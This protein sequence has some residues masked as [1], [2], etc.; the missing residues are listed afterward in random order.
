MKV[1]STI[2][3]IFFSFICLWT[4]TVANG[5]ANTSFPSFV[6]DQLQ[7]DWPE[8]GS[9][10]QIVGR[11]FAKEVET[12]ISDPSRRIFIDGIIDR[13]FQP[14][15][16]FPNGDDPLRT[17]LVRVSSNEKFTSL[18]HWLCIMVELDRIKNYEAYNDL[19]KD[20]ALGK[21]AGEELSSRVMTLDLKNAIESATRIAS[22]NDLNR[23][24]VGRSVVLDHLRELSGRN[25]KDGISLIRELS[26]EQSAKDLWK[27]Y[28]TTSE[29]RRSMFIPTTELPEHGDDFGERMVKQLLVDRPDLAP[30]SRETELMARSVMRQINATRDQPRIILL[31]TMLQAGKACDCRMSFH[32]ASLDC[33]HVGNLDGL[34]VYDKWLLIAFEIQRIRQNSSRMALIRQFREDKTIS[35]KEYVLGMCRLDVEALKN[36]VTSLFDSNAIS[37]DFAH[38]NSISKY[39]YGLQI[40]TYPLSSIVDKTREYFMIGGIE[41]PQ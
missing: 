12:A 9:P 41:V 37:H 28:S 30:N 39:A 21:V 18:D 4:A 3:L 24:P 15:Y 32:F 25:L 13:D 36:A 40:E 33:V 16:W 1:L 23:I 14:A 34:F 10:D 31:S 7:R 20:F 17:H 26:R 35:S 22:S 2:K 5:Q 38:E 29:E 19:M 6:L 11:Q 8:L 27:F